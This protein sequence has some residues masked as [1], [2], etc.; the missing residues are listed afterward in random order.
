MCLPLPHGK[1][2][3]KFSGK[4]RVVHMPVQ[5]LGHVHVYKQAENVSQVCIGLS[6]SGASRVWH[7]VF[8]ACQAHHPL[9]SAHMNVIGIGTFLVF[10]P[11]VE[12]ILSDADIVCSKNQ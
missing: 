6:L 11:Q 1:Q 10:E 3:D 2:F 9:E 4:S 8:C 12:E 5:Q 7:A